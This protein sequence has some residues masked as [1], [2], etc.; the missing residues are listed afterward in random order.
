M[1]KL[2]LLVGRG[3]KLIYNLSSA[4]FHRKYPCTFSRTIYTGA[5]NDL[6]NVKCA[7]MWYEC[8]VW[9]MC[10]IAYGTFVMFRREIGC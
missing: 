3:V 9:V 6:F 4:F 7:P 5:D 10:E 1:C 8:T 2:V